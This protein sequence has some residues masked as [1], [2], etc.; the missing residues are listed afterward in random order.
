M[1]Y[2]ILTLQECISLG[3]SCYWLYKITE[4]NVV[5]LGHYSLSYQFNTFDVS[6]LSAITVCGVSKL[7]MEGRVNVE[8]FTTAF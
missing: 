6:Y 3:R 4:R 1:S 8:A 5:S 7:G 2:M